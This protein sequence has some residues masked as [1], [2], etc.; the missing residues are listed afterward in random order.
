MTKTRKNERL[1]RAAEKPLLS[2]LPAFPGIIAAMKLSPTL[3]EAL[4]KQ[5]NV[6]L[7]DD[8]AGST[9]T[10][11]EREMIAT[12]VSANNDCFFCMDSHGEF[13]RGLLIQEG[14][15]EDEADETVC[16][17][18]DGYFSEQDDKMIALI[19]IAIQV[20]DRPR[21]LTTD[22]INEALSEGAT[23]QDVQLAI[24]IGAGFAMYNRLVDGFRA[25]TP[26]DVEMHRPVAE[27]IIAGGYL[28]DR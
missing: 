26:P 13:A 24:M 10:R 27:Q 25:T 5:A 20:T 22:L 2:S 6:L 28:R 21:K 14:K 3:E 23:E 12:A 19:R 16:E 1:Q 9:L 4:S 18:K 11:A 8:Y 15:T 7:V 17:L